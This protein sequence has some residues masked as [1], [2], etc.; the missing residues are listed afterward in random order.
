[1]KILLYHQQSQHQAQLIMAFHPQTI[2]QEITSVSS[3]SVRH[4][5]V[6]YMTT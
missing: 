3:A 2:C 6:T 4:H 1:M 5:R